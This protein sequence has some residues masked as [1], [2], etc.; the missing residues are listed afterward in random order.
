MLADGGVCLIDEFDGIPEK[1]RHAE[2]SQDVHSH[3][4][5]VPARRLPAHLSAVSSK[6]LI[7]VAAVGEYG[8]HVPTLWPGHG[9][10]PLPPRRASIHEAMEQQTTSVAKAGMMV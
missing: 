5:W 7:S 10:A 3:S 2:H 8:F 6:W 1:G 4:I 9:A